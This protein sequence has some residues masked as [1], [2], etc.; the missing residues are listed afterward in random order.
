[1]LSVSLKTFRDELTEYEADGVTLAPEAVSIFVSLIGAMAEEAA[2]LEA[3][4]AAAPPTT[5]ELRLA[6]VLM[7]RGVRVGIEP[8]GEN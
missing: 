8:K 1:M 5:A 6:K 3:R 7:K 4:A 2:S